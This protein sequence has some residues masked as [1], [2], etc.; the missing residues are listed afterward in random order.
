MWLPAEHGNIGE[1]LRRHCLGTDPFPPPPD[2]CVYE[3]VQSLFRREL[4]DSEFI[5]PKAP[6]YAQRDGAPGFFAQHN[7]VILRIGLSGTV[8]DPRM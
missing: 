4:L 3:A 7:D 8:P 1:P 2:H 6:F 5:G